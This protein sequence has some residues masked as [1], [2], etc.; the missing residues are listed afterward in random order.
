MAI[1]MDDEEFAETKRVLGLWEVDM[2]EASPS[3]EQAAR[4][5]DL[6]IRALNLLQLPPEKHRQ[7]ANYIARWQLLQARAIA[8]RRLP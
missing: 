4:I 5:A 1:T 6:E 7:R 2:R 3:F 8:R